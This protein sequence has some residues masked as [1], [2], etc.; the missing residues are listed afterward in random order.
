MY[1]ERKDHATGLIC[2][3]IIG[4][5]V[6]TQLEFVVQRRLVATRTLLAG[7]Y[8]GSPNPATAQLTAE[9]LLEAFQELTLTI[10][11]KGHHQRYHLTALSALQRRI[12]S[13]LD[14][15]LDIYTRFC[16]DAHTLPKK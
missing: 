4:L 15:P 5:Q 3:L 8:V 2:L 1:L 13:L 9:R 16:V 6:L 14:F 7:L 12:L 11:R 10:I